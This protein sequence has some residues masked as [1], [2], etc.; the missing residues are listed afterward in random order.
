MDEPY[1]VLIVSH[2]SA[3]T[4]SACLEAVFHLEPA[5]S[6]V[7]VVDNASSDNSREIARS[8]DSRLENLDENL[9]FTG[10]MN[11]GIK[12]LKSPWILSLNPDCAP[13]RD[14]TARLFD[15]IQQVPEPEKIGS[16]TGLLMRAETRAL[17]PGPVIDSA[18]MIVTPSGRHF[19]RGAGR[20]LAE[21]NLHPAW[22][23]GGTGAATLYRRQALKD[24]A[25]ED[26][27]VFA[28]TFFAYREDAE[29]AWRLQWRGWSCL[30]EPGAMAAH[31]RRLR[32]E[33]GRR[34]LP[35][36]I[37]RYSVRNRFLMRM[38]CADLGWHLHCFP[39]WFLRDLLVTAACLSMEI[40]SLPGLMDLLRLRSDAL[41]RRHWV[42]SRRRIS[43]RQMS[44]HFRRPE[45]WVEEITPR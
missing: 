18:G 43:S 17:E 42:L 8:F 36:E 45:G 10:G 19:D 7:L 14:F 27:S 39:H 2:N 29:L 15:S 11:H 6:K 34:G 33:Q 38:H 9:G 26:G 20:V 28:P 5:P 44:R 23:F 16:A 31:R 30:F 21:L 1:D 37:N 13:N 12:L 24:V 35:N 40:S 22:V 32:P 25:Y 41:A 4:L 3:D